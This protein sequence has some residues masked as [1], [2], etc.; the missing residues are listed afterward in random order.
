MP[1]LDHQLLKGS[2]DILL[3]VLLERGPRY[4][5]QIVKEV[6]ERSEGVLDLKQGTLYPALHRLEQAGMVEGYWET[7]PDGADRR[8]YRL[9]PQ[10]AAAAQDHRAA[11][12]RFSAAVDGV[13]RYG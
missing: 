7:R 6:R 2:L 3:L 5:Y 1:S 4:G 11:W 10:G 12:Q 13:L 9:T 8:Y